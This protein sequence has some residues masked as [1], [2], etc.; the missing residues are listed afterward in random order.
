MLNKRE[1][2]KILKSVVCFVLNLAMLI[3]FAFDGRAQLPVGLIRKVPLYQ[4]PV[5]DFD[6]PDPTVIRASDG[7]YYGYATQTV[8]T[9]VWR[10][11]QIARSIDLIHWEYLGDALPVKPAWAN[12]T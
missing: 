4:N 2:E 12:Q 1:N 10:N 11:I 8:V 5:Y 7:Y 3:A 6:F 9:G